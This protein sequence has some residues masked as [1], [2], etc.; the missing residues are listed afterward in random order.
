MRLY[1]FYGQPGARL[2]A[3]LSVYI[4]GEHGDENSLLFAPFNIFLFFAPSVQIKELKRIWVDNIVNYARWEAF[5]SK[6]N[7]EWSGITIYVSNH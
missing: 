6:L 7:S 1:S 2:E 3:N 5:S 4:G